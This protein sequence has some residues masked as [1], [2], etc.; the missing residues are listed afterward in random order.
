M[1][2]EVTL[3]VVYDQLD[4][5]SGQLFDVKAQNITRD[6]WLDKGEWLEAANRAG[7]ESIFFIDNN[8]VYILALQYRVSGVEDTG[9][10]DT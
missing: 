1:K 10:P 5:K 6:D 7:A 9:S 8:P 4:F 3:E 2:S